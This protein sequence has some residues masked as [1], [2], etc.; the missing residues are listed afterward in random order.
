[1]DYRD[2]LNHIKITYNL[3]SYNLEEGFEQFARKK[4]ETLDRIEDQPF[5][6]VDDD[7]NDIII[8]VTIE[9]VAVDFDK[10]TGEGIVF[11]YKFKAK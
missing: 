1:M 9:S 8:L 3:R 6:W 7:G 4:M 11:E 5:D 10:E 2:F